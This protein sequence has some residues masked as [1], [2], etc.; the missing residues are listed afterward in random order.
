M[1]E[2]ESGRPRRA[3]SGVQIGSSESESP[4]R[5]ASDAEMMHDCMHKGTCRCGD[6]LSTL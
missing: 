3:P 4:G 1:I 6:C 2:R 5:D